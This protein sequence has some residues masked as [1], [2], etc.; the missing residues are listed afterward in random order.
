MREDVTALGR[1][2]ELKNLKLM[3]ALYTSMDNLEHVIHLNMRTQGRHRLIGEKQGK[4]QMVI[5]R[6]NVLKETSST[7]EQQLMDGINFSESYPRGDCIKNTSNKPHKEVS[8]L[9]T[10]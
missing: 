1:L 6:L 10:R 5:T 4:V 2:E 9:R 8:S 7:F 3:A